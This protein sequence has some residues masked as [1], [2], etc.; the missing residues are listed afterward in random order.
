[1]EAPL[2]C[3]TPASEKEKK[4]STCVCVSLVVRDLRAR[5]AFLLRL[6]R[7]YYIVG[8]GR[9]E[10]AGT[11]VKYMYSLSLS[12]LPTEAISG[13]DSVYVTSALV[14]P[15]LVLRAH[16]MRCQYE[17]RQNMVELECSFSPLLVRRA[18]TAA[19][20]R[21][22]E[23]E[24]K[25]ATTAPLALSKRNNS[26]RRHCMQPQRGGEREAEVVVNDRHRDRTRFISL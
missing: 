17:W 9:G 8:S 4:K 15:L 13:S 1:M 11:R 23:R 25:V 2:N 14:F 3:A 21:Q 26:G 19:V 20:Y 22:R 16:C 18:K 7:H 12:R 5:V 6:C 10:G 24:R